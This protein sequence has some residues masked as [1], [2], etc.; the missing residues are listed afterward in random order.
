METKISPALKEAM[1][2]F[3]KALDKAVL[4]IESEKLEKS[5]IKVK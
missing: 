1:E 3:S 4:T 2:L 5:Y